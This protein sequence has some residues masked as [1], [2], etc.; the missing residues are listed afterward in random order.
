MYFLCFFRLNLYINFNNAIVVKAKPD[1][2]LDEFK[3][4]V[5]E[6]IIPCRSPKIYF[7]GL[8][9]R[10]GEQSLAKYGIVNQSSLYVNTENVV[11]E[12]Q[13]LF[14]AIK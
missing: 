6:K 12:C 7:N 14:R 4:Y 3:I 5:F 8:L 2:T 10:C 1:L 13:I 11:G 9:M